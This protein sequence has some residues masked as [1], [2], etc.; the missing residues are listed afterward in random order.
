MLFIFAGILF[1]IL[2]KIVEFCSTI[3]NGIGRAV[4]KIRQKNINVE[5]SCVA[6]KMEFRTDAGTET[7]LAWE[8]TPH[9]YVAFATLAKIGHPLLYSEDD[10][11]GNGKTREEYLSEFTEDSLR[12]V[13]GMPLCLS[14]PESGTYQGNKSGVGIGHFMQEILVT[15]KG[16]LLAPVSVT[17][18]RGIELIDKC[19]AAGKIPEISPAYWVESVSSDGKGRYEQRRGRYDHA[20]LLLP[21]HGRGGDSISLRLDHSDS[22]PLGELDVT[23]TETSATD[24]ARIETEKVA[25][26]K[27]IETLTGEIAGL[28][29][30]L[31]GMETTHLS[32]DAVT[33]KFNTLA[34][35]GR[36]NLDSIDLALSSA[37]LQRQHIKSLNPTLDLTGKSDDYVAG[38]FES[39]VTPN[40]IAVQPQGL[41]QDSAAVIATAQQQLTAVQSDNSLT[42]DPIALAKAKRLAQI[43]NAYTIPVIP[44]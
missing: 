11:G 40:T 2:L 25:L 15:D 38:V 33:A 5:E 1:K 19:L 30:Q 43:E 18:S 24:L 42:T 22:V 17:D 12:S 29:S 4:G 20:A 35:I 6:K 27:Q 13:R 32:L 28:K 3:I 36:I 8:K 9:G 37:A 26:T 39:L 44:G 31:T 21:G 7:K 23:T 34:R 10:V 41:T 14:H 16:E